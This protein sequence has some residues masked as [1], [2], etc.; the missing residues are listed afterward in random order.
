MAKGSPGG[1]VK[2][3]NWSQDPANLCWYRTVTAYS[4]SNVSADTSGGLVPIRANPPT[5][6]S[7]P[8]DSASANV[9]SR[10]AYMISRPWLRPALALLFTSD[11]SITCWYLLSTSSSRLK[12]SLNWPKRNA[13]SLLSMYRIHA[14][15]RLL[16]PGMRAKSPKSPR[17][18]NV[19]SRLNMWPLNTSLARARSKPYLDLGGEL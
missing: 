5:L 14:S 17:I 9:L 18:L 11:R 19:R 2:C 16:A 1:L 15:S 12:G 8:S 7:A 10:S 3:L 13:H 4:V 6:S